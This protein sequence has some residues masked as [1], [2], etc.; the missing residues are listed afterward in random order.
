MSNIYIMQLHITLVAYD[1][2][3]TFGQRPAAQV[4]AIG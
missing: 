1:L 3:T 2:A 4:L